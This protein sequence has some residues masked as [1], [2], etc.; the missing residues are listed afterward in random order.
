MGSMENKCSHRNARNERKFGNDLISEELFDRE[1]TLT[2]MGSSSYNILNY[3]PERVADNHIKNLELVRNV[4]DG[5]YSYETKQDFI[6]GRLGKLKIQYNQTP[7]VFSTV[8]VPE[9]EEY[10]DI[11]SIKRKIKTNKVSKPA[12]FS[13]ENFKSPYTMMSCFMFSNSLLVTLDP[14]VAP[15]NPFSIIAF[16]AGSLALLHSQY[17]QEKHSYFK[18]CEKLDI[19]NLTNKIPEFSV[20]TIV[21][22]KDMSNDNFPKRKK[23]IYFEI[24]EDEKA[25]S[26]ISTN[27]IN[28]LL[29][30]INN[31]EEVIT[32]S[33]EAEKDFS[34][35][36]NMVDA[37]M[38]KALFYRG[39]QFLEY[40]I[41]DTSD[42]ETQNLSK[43]GLEKLDHHIEEEDERITELLSKSKSI[44]ETKHFSDAF[45]YVNNI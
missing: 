9:L 32:D 2:Q 23:T 10:L 31:L 18:T 42:E 1:V 5:Y 35:Q 28:E 14:M 41:S 20:P 45:N 26:D 25:K 12:F 33:K 36:K 15:I 37:Y 21:G 29:D 17:I 43:T 19:I 38:R 39:K 22:I 6:T 4:H 8:P 27:T 11:N 3:E 30:R 16:G 7:I 44:R 40:K 24:D 34:H 13:K